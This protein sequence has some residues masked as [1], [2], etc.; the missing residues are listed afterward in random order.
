MPNPKR[1][2]SKTRKGKRRAHLALTPPQ[3]HRCPRSGALT[4]S[5]RMSEEA[6]HYGF[7]RGGTKGRVVFER[8]DAEG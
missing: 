4:L 6:T 7:E 3:P 2:A 5:H 1:R 8:D